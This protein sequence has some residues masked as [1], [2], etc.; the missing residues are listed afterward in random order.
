[1]ESSIIHRCVINHIS[2][3]LLMIEINFIDKFTNNNFFLYNINEQVYIT[4]NSIKYI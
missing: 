4:I 3:V 1:M 2:Y